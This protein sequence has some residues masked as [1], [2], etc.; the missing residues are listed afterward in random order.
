MKMGGREGV[1]RMGGKEWG[2]LERKKTEN[3]LAQ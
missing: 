1:G 2:E 3:M